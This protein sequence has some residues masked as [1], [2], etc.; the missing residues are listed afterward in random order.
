MDSSPRRKPWVRPTAFPSPAPEGG[1]GRHAAVKAQSHPPACLSAASCGGRHP[2]SRITPTACAVGYDLAR[3][4]GAT[5]AHT[6]PGSPVVRLLCS[7]WETPQTSSEEPEVRTRC[8]TPSGKSRDEKWQTPSAESSRHRAPRRGAKRIAQGKPRAKR[9][10]QPW[11][12]R[13]PKHQAPEGRQ[14]RCTRRRFCRP[15]GA[16]FRLR[17]S[18]GG[19]TPSASAPRATADRGYC[20]SAP[21]GRVV[22][23]LRALLSGRPNRSVTPC[24]LD[25]LPNQVLA[26]EYRLRLPD[27]KMLAAERVR[28]R[29]RLDRRFL[30]PTRKGARR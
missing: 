11:V 14:S 3:P 26:T 5:E 12:A 23:R 1:Q 20:L 29:H 13:T 10:A 24:A 2:S 30:A 19:F 17:R 4:S 28:I 27:E 22:R 6:F 18:T 9:G 25:A 7:G 21:S 15:S 8:P 16:G